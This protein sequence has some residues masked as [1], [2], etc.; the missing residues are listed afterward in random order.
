LA[1]ELKIPPEL[2]LADFLSSR[3]AG[4]TLTLRSLS[5]SELFVEYSDIIHAKIIINQASKEIRFELYSPKWGRHVTVED[6]G[7]FDFLESQ[8]QEELKKED[9]EITAMDMMLALDL[10]RSWAH[11]RKY[12]TVEVRFGEANNPEGQ[13]EG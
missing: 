1:D 7:G 11:A 6:L 4:S 8:A 10:L 13:R 5:S 12:V 3:L 9:R 2:S